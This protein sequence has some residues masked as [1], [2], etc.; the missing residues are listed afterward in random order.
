M[1]SQNWSVRLRLPDGKIHLLR[2]SKPSD[3]IEVESSGVYELLEV[4]TGQFWGY[5]SVDLLTSVA[6]CNTGRG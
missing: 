5:P 4:R 2:V 3:Q 6:A 1:S